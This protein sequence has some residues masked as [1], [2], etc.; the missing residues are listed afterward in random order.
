MAQYPAEYVAWAKEHDERLSELGF[1]RWF[2][3]VINVA[4]DEDVS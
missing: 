1:G 2:N 4:G 3:T